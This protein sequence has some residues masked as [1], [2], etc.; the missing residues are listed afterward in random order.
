MVSPYSGIM[1]CYA[2]VMG[3][4]PLLEGVALALGPQWWIHD[5][6]LWILIY[7]DDGVYS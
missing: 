1:L 5:S 6:T 2:I 3:L 4:P 7:F